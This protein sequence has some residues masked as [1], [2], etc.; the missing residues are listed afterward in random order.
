[1]KPKV[2]KNETEYQ[3]TLERINELM[4]A[5]PGTEAFDELELLAILADNYENEA[6]PIELP[7]PI[8]A[9]RFRMDQAGLKQKDLVPLIGSRSKVSEVLSGKRTL[10]L[11]MM[12]NLHRELGI[13]AEVLLQE[14][15][16]K[17]TSPLEGVEW[18]RFPMKEL[19]G[20]NW[21]AG[22]KGSLSEAK[23]KAEEI[24]SVW[25][26]PLGEGALEPALLRQHV[27]A[28]GT[29]DGYA[30]TAWKIRVSLLALEQELPRYKPGTVTRDFVR[31]LVRLSYL[32]NGPLLAQEYLHKNGIHFVVEPHLPHTHLDGAA[33]RLPDGSPL[34]ALTL[35]HD[36][37]DNFWFTLCHELAHVALHFDDQES[38]VFFDDL[39]QQ[40]VDALETDADH[41]AVETLI[42]AEAW[43]AAGLC[44]DP[45]P[46]R[47]R[48]FAAVHRISPVIPAGRVRR[49]TGN[50]RLFGSYIAQQKVRYLWKIS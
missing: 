46:A 37:L 23:E 40:Q 44:R 27:R 24:L 49:E 10:S 17:I 15:G 21:I 26:S 29:A 28:G 13:P 1:M 22:F 16:A 31:D 20:R 38:I 7:D 2:I 47:V 42:P 41:W 5:E 4:D 12:R 34:V 19:L 11:A 18:E 14:P 36:R 48:A 32:D 25:A 9:I 43:N 39:D 35:R 30:L 33:I 6:H 3:A 50:Y 45:K 8:A